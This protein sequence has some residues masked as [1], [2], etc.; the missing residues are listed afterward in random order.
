MLSAAT[1][2]RRSENERA[3]EALAASVSW[4]ALAEQL[5]R[6]RLL[7]TLGPRLID[8]AK[9]GATPEFAAVV[10]EAIKSSARQEQLLE[11]ITSRVLSALADAGVRSSALKGPRLGRSLYGGAG[12]RPSADIDVLV[13]KER[14][15]E[16]VE[17]V[18]G[19]GYASSETPT[20]SGRPLLHFAMLHLGGEL[21]PVELHW[22]IHWYESRFA[23]DRLLPPPGGAQVEWAPAPVDQLAALLLYYARDGFFSLRYATDIG[24]W[25]DAHGEELISGS[26]DQLCSRYPAIAGAMGAAAR[27]AADAVGLPAARVLASSARL[28]IRGRVAVGLADPLPRGTEAQ[29]NAEMGL[30]DGMLAPLAGLARFF[31]RQIAPPREVLRA[32]IGAGAEG[33]RLSG[34]GHSVR[35]L[36][37]YGLAI[38]RLW[39][40]E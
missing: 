15:A 39:A 28:G 31:R 2:L 33:D 30:I 8:L 23:Q 6:R 19:L 16:A 27:A 29:I 11:L 18:A 13:E 20:I 7:A 22:R 38:G 12:R 26:L 14:I 4:P 10:A 37:R 9:G 34:L 35:V 25:W 3:A 5:A 32:R 36:R 40:A 17:A 1:A 21:P 24:A